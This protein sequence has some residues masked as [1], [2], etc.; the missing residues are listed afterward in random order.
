[1]GDCPVQHVLQ[2]DCR[3]SPGSGQESLPVSAENQREGQARL[4]VAQF[5]AQS[6][7]LWPTDQQRVGNAVLLSKK[8]NRAWRVGGYSYELNA[9]RSVVLADSRKVGHFFAAGCAPC[10]PEVDDK[11]FILP[12]RESLWL[13]FVIVELTVEQGGQRAL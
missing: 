7:D 4:R 3:K 1:M 12:L 11:D 6:D 10:C 2:F 13:S 5:R 8:T 9:F